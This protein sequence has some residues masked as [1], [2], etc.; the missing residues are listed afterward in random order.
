M[1]FQHTVLTIAIVILI[2]CLIILAIMMWNE[3]GDL[4]FP[5]EIG[6]CPDYFVMKE[7]P[8]HYCR[9]WINNENYHL[10]FESIKELHV[11]L[12]SS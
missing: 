12:L 1:S 7:N 11:T 6:N 10:Y 3:K 2:I 5:P 4:V 8:N 9:G